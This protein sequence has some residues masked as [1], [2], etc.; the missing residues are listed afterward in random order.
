MN[1]FDSFRQELQF[2]RNSVE[3]FGHAY[4][5]IAAELKLSAGRSADPHVEQLLQSFAYLTGKL[6]ADVDLQRGETANQML[7]ALYPSLVRSLPCMTTLQA[8]VTTDGANFINGSMLEK[9]KQFNAK[10]K[11]SDQQHDCYLQSCYDTPLWPFLIDDIKVLPKNYYALVDQNKDT[12]TVLSVKVSSEGMDAIYEYPLTKLRFYITDSSQ[13]S[14]LFRMLNDSLIGVAIKVGD[15]V[16]MLKSSEL[17]W[18]GFAAD[19]NVL[20]DD[21]QDHRAYRLLQEYFAFPDKFYF[22][23]LLGIDNSGI[24]DQFELLFMF[25]EPRH[26]IQVTKTSLALNCFPAVNLYQKTFKPIQLQQTTHE[27]RLVADER[28]YLTNEVHSIT[29]VRSIGYDG[30]VK[31]VEPWLGGSNVSKKSSQYFV[32]RL[33]PILKASESGCDTMLSLYDAKFSLCDQV[34]QTLTI[35]GWC[36]NRRLPEWLRIGHSLKPVGTAPID[37]ARVIE[38]PTRFKSANLTPGNNIKLLSQLTLNQIALGD[39]KDRLSLLKQ[40]LTLY[41]DPKALSHLRQIDGL[42]DWHSEPIVKRVGK[43]TWRGH[44]RGIRL[45]LVIDEHHF[46]DANPLLLANVLSHFFGLYTTLNHFVQLQLVSHQREGVWKKW[47]PRIGEQ[48]L[49]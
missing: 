49:L 27:Y 2:L 22:F 42:I 38:Q 45:T 24:K 48:V 13:R 33:V 20:P 31:V 34:D 44:C 9:G 5:S 3:D 21:T 19:E 7:H 46:T 14:A 28:A 32:S 29:E 15:T 10:A 41:A 40:L 26:D 11:T 47:P 4:P 35:K 8:E 6:R 43:A 36:N 30:Q 39:G 17:H 1:H 12:Q 18:L 25:D 37:C 23:D 16:S